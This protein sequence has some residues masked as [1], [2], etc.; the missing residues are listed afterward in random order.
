MAS[1]LSNQRLRA[2]AC[3]LLL[4]R[5]CVVSMTKSSPSLT[6]LT[7]QRSFLITPTRSARAACVLSV[8]SRHSE[9][10][11]SV[12][13]RR[14]RVQQDHNDVLEDRRFLRRWCVIVRFDDGDARALDVWPVDPADVECRVIA[15]TGSCVG[16]ECGTNLAICACRAE[17]PCSSSLLEPANCPAAPDLGCLRFRSTRIAP[18]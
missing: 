1:G 10:A 2:G 15:S 17:P 3:C 7:I 18:R 8:P 5:C 14:D 12:T 6:R 4:W 9:C 13:W 11:L 16:V